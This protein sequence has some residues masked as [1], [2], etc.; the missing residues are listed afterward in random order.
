LPPRPPLAGAALGGGASAVFTAWHAA[1][2]GFAAAAGPAASITTS[3]HS[4]IRLFWTRKR[5]AVR[6][7][8]Y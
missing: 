1:E 3:S 7:P 2:F 8:D 4:V 5:L 6:V